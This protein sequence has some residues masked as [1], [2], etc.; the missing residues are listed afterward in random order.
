MHLAH[1]SYLSN[2]SM[3]RTCKRLLPFLSSTA[4]NIVLH[5]NPKKKLV[6]VKHDNLVVGGFMTR[7][8]ARLV[9][10]EVVTYPI[11]QS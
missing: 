11:F 3:D 6:S 7:F 9:L 8:K 2:A 5:K 10:T 1:H 4:R